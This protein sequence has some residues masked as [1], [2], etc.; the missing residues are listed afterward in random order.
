MKTPNKNIVLNIQKISI[1]FCALATVATLAVAEIGHCTQNDR[2][3]AAGIL[4]SIF[5]TAGLGL[6]VGGYL[7]NPYRKKERD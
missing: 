1:G 4:G 7:S 6:A 2:A 5:T 3:Y